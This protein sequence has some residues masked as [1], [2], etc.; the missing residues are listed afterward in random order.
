MTTPTN[1]AK[2]GA[3]PDSDIDRLREIQRAAW[4]RFEA[5]KLELKAAEEA[6]HAATSAIHNHPN[7]RRLGF[8][9]R[10]LR[11]PTMKQDDLS[12]CGLGDPMP[13]PLAIYE[14]KF[15]KE[16]DRKLAVEK[17][18]KAAE[19]QPPMYIPPPKPQRSDCGL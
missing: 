1:L 6:A 3:A 5:A 18:R 17:A 13:D 10:L 19:P 11:R 2:P 8:G 4:A 16:M 7:G 9:R 14:A 15:Q 12:H